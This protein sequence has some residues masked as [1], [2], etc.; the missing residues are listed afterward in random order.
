MEQML[1]EYGLPK[2]IVTVIMMLYEDMK[3]MVR[4][5]GGDVEKRKISYFG[6]AHNLIQYWISPNQDDLS[7]SA[8]TF[9]SG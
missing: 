2:E 8:Q 3:A 7:Y 6:L 4:S 5:L 1:L 9:I